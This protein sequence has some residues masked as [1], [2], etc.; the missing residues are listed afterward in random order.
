MMMMIYD[1]IRTTDVTV[2]VERVPTHALI[3]SDEDTADTGAGIVTH[4]VG[5]WASTKQARRTQLTSTTCPHSRKTC[6]TLLIKL[7]KQASLYKVP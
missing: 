1:F 3:S 4:G 6:K 7:S 2:A 5:V